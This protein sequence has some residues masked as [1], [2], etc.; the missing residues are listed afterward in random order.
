[1]ARTKASNKKK[2][3][4]EAKIAEKLP[5]KGPRPHVFRPAS[6]ILKKSGFIN[7]ITLY[8]YQ[9]QHFW[10]ASKMLYKNSRKLL[11]YFPKGS[12]ESEPKPRNVAVVGGGIIK[13]FILRR[14]R[15][16]AT[17]EE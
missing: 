2:G 6:R 9:N 17:R 13:R 14:K 4:M 3:A 5:K 8:F 1:M 16:S 10:N 7:G 11:K 12:S 15:I